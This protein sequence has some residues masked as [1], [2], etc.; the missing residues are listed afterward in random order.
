MKVW[1]VV[2]VT[3][4]SSRAARRV[5]VNGASASG[6][7]RSEQNASFGTIRAA[8]IAIERSDNRRIAGP[9]ATCGLV[10]AVSPRPTRRAETRI[11]WLRQTEDRAVRA[12][13]PTGGARACNGRDL[14]LA[15]DVRDSR[16]WATSIGWV[17]LDSAS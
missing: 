6:V 17:V 13:T 4:R 1:Q 2:N 10:V 3:A 16:R 9:V 11:Q 5:V 7:P 8:G 14:L 15:V 12:Q